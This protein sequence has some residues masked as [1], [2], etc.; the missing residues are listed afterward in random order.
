MTVNLAIS[1]VLTIK[2]EQAY[3][4]VSWDIYDFFLLSHQLNYS[5]Q[6]TSGVR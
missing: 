4:H 5:F 2:N 1:L 6:W 3:L